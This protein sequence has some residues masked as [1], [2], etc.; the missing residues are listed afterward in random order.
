MGFVDTALEIKFGQFANFFSE[1]LCTCLS[2]CF[3]SALIPVN[4]ISQSQSEML[5][6][7]EDNDTH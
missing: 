1:K 6:E 2:C 7:T 3:T 4:N 5:V